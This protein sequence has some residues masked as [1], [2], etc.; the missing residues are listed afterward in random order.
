[1]AK[2]HNGNWP[3]KMMS[4]PTEMKGK[5]KMGEWRFGIER[6]DTEIKEI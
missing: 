2:L 3:I 6:R 4:E 5:P 1:M